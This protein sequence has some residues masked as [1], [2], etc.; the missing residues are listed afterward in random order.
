MKNLIYSSALIFSFM[1]IMACNK[2][3][4]IQPRKG[5]SQA[6]SLAAVESPNQRCDSNAF[7]KYVLYNSTG[8]GSFTINFSGENNYSFAFPAYGS[9]TVDVKP[10]IYNIQI[11]PTGNFTS[12]GFFMDGKP[13][14]KAP[15]A[16]Y[17]SVKIGPCSVPLQTSIN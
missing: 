12:H 13:D 16:R 9:K 10:G 4:A 7:V 5:L 2:N 17:E 14:V 8:I 6:D 11:P 1:I 3:D 15:T